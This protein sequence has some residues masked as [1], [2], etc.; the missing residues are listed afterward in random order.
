MFK[1]YHNNNGAVNFHIIILDKIN[2]IE[3]ITIFKTLVNY[4][5]YQ[6]LKVNIC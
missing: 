5:L 4:Q 6:N 3:I 1:N 2:K